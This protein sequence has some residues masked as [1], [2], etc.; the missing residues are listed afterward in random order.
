MLNKIKLRD[1]RSR[2]QVHPADFEAV[3]EDLILAIY[4]SEHTHHDYKLMDTKTFQIYHLPQFYRL[5]ATRIAPF[6]YK[7]SNQSLREPLSWKMA[8]KV[9]HAFSE[10]RLYTQRNILSKEQEKFLTTRFR[11]GSR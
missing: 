5:L 2:V 9:A 4:G 7:S 10:A 1:E 3:G 8:L 6:V 11:D